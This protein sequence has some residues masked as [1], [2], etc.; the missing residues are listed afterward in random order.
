[1]DNDEL[2]GHV[3]KRPSARDRS[4]VASG[5]L[6]CPR[7]DAPV[8]PDG[9][10]ALSALLLCPVCDRAGPVRDFLSLTQPT[11]AA[12]VVVRLS[13]RRSLAHVHRY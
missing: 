11:R 3:E 5:T 1:V 12:H 9:S 2:P 8:A 10:M 4:V 7:C 6:A 13:G